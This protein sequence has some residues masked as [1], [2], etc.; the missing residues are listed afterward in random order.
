MHSVKVIK[1]MEYSQVQQDP[2]RSKIE[3]NNKV[4]MLDVGRSRIDPKRSGIG[5]AVG[6]SRI[7]GKKAKPGRTALKRINDVDEI[8]S[9]IDSE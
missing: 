2:L 3:F 6:K 7:G 1:E 8:C 9:V 4:K 5:D